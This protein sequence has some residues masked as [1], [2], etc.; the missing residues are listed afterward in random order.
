MVWCLAGALALAT[1]VL[2]VEKIGHQP[3]PGADWLPF[4]IAGGVALDARSILIASV[5]GAGPD[6]RGGGARPGVRA[7]R[8]VEHRLTLPDPIRETQAGRAL[9]ADAIRHV[10]DLDVA[11]R[12]GLAIPRRAWVPLVPVAGWP[13]W[14]CSRPKLNREDGPGPRP[15]RHQGSEKALV[16]QELDRP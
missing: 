9:I 8:A 12:F 16:D 2:G 1:A 15:R 13:A 7:Q 4:A 6:R 10:A 3:I 11:D 14:S 5:L